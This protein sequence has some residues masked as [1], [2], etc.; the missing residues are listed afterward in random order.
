[1]KL[2]TNPWGLSMLAVTFLVL[3]PAGKASAGLLY[4]VTVDTSSFAGAPG[5]LE[6]QLNGVANADY[7]QGVISNF[8]STGGTLGTIYPP[9]NDAS[10]DLGTTVTLDNASGVTIPNDFLQ[11]FT[12][13]SSFTFLVT[14]TG[15]GTLLPSVQTEFSMTLWDQQGG[16]GDALFP[17]GGD[18]T[19][20]A[21]ALTIDMPVLNVV[22][23]DP[24]VMPTAV[25][26]PGSLVAL[27]SGMVVLLT[28]GLKRRHCR[29]LRADR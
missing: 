17:I 1:M 26:E 3:G 18:P 8:T 21:P 29:G 25:P 28:Y 2:R 14:F 27:T 4:Q 24:A 20:G 22:A 11:D 13:G 7:V 23:G 15:P 16:T 10:G 5:S 9:I 19:S 12:Y 6:F